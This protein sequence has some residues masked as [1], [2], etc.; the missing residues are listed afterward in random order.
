[1]SDRAT[2]DG[3]THIFLVE[4]HPAIQEA[5]KDGVGDTLDIEVC[6]TTTS[7]TDALRQIEELRPDVVVVDISLQDGHGLEFI[8]HSQSRYPDIELIVFSMYDEMVYAERA[9]RRG[10]S[11]YL[12]KNEPVNELIN[13]IRAVNDGDVY[14]SDNMASRIL[15]KVAKGDSPDPGFPT[16]ELTD[17]ELA[18]FQMLGKGHNIEEIQNRLN[19][20]RKTVEAYRRRAKEKLGFDSVTELLQYA[21][22]WSTAPG[23]GAETPTSMK[24]R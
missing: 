4:D 21:V 3:R 8:E 18:V 1:M 22:R 19:I 13:G 7:S 9:I 11:G 17:R 23:D 15:N 24:E 6:G 14:L 12:M 10:A 20:A 16:D 5:I 2:D